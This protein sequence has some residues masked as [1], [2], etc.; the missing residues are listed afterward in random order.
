ML[1]RD[2]SRVVWIVN[3]VCML[4]IRQYHAA[5]SRASI[6]SPPGLELGRMRECHVHFTMRRLGPIP[7]T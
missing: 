7:E 4:S 2:Y 6:S 5:I 3:L 1:P